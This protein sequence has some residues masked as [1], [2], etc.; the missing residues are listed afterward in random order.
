MVA[1]L[2]VL[3]IMVQEEKPLSDLA[4]AMTRYPQVLLN[5]AVARKRPLEEMPAVTKAI[6]KVERELGLDG[7]VVV[8]YSGTESKARIMIEGTDEG[9]I[10]AQAEEIASVLKRELAT[11]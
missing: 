8:R 5:F 2:R 6:S 10:K 7:R 4:R 11:A 9:R 1:A 3:A